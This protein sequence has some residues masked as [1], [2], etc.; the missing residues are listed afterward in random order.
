MLGILLSFAISN[1]GLGLR[2]QG[3]GFGSFVLTLVF[4]PPHPR[5]FFTGSAFLS[6]EDFV[7]QP[8]YPSPYLQ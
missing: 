2:V 5:T 6:D 1:E 4:F 8:L 7:W 3:L